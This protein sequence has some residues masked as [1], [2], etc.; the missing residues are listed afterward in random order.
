MS[1]ILWDDPNFTTGGYDAGLAYAQSK[2]ANVL[3]T[4]ELDRRW[5]ADGIRAFAAHPGVIA[6]TAFN[7][8]VGEDGQR[9]MGL[10]DESGQPIIDPERGK[11]TPEQGAATLVFGATSPLLAEIGGVYLNNNDVSQL[12]DEQP[13][14]TAEEITGDVVSH[15][16]DPRSAQRLWELSEELLKA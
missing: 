7:S 3:F 10:I 1:D 13:P 4:V 14:V 2:T 6:A 15:S 5:A 16:I 12:N 9:A 8:S 11:K